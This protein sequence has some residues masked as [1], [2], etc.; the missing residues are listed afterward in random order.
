VSAILHVI[1][2]H[3]PGGE[4]EPTSESRTSETRAHTRM[5]RMREIY[6]MHEYRVREWVPR[7]EAVLAQREACA[8]VCEAEARRLRRATGV[9]AQA[10]HAEALNCADAIRRQP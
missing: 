7:G 5:L 8:E 4:W 10:R 6:P 1:E 2:I 9:A 3:V